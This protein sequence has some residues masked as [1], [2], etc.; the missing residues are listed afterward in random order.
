MLVL[1]TRLL[2][3][4]EILWEK[5]YGGKNSEYLFDAI[6]TPD[7][8]F[9]LAGSS[10][11]GKGGSKSDES[12]G[13]YDYWVWKMTEKGDLEWQKSFG[14]TADDHL[15]SIRLT[16]DGGFILAGISNS[17]KDGDKKEDSKGESDFW[18]IKLDAK[19]GEL[20][21]RTIGGNGL[22]NLYSIASTSDGGYIIG[23]TSSSEI[24]PVPEDGKEDEFRKTVANYG[25]LDYWVIKLNASGNITWQKTYGGSY[26]DELR[27]IE[28]TK[29]GGYIIGG[30]SNS[31]MSGNKTE[32]NFGE[33]D[34]WILKLDAS[35]NIT[36]QKTIGGDQDD[37]LFVLT[38]TF[39][40]GF[41]AGGSSN[42]GAM[43][44]K[45]KG[46][47]KGTDFWILKFD[48]NGAV[49]WQ[50]TYDYGKLDVLTSI[51]ENQDGTLLIGGYAQSEA[52]YSKGILGKLAKASDKEGINDYIALKISSKGEE[53]WTQTVGSRGDEVLRK[54]VETRDGGYV[55]AGTSNGGAS[56]DKNSVQGGNDFWVV[57]LKDKDKKEETRI[58]LE[59]IPNP[60]ITYSNVIVNY[61]YKKGTA[62]LYDL[63]GRILQTYSIHGERTIP[64][65]LSGLPRAIYVVEIKTDTES[66]GVKIIKK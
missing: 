51:V 3:S 28:P 60:A 37:N 21:Q 18:I 66:G 30:Y 4:Q 50:E 56:R 19:G 13:N 43:N 47:G 34:Y 62:T 41:I 46:N 31:P 11:S 20:W 61:E 25:N 55:L 64:V 35:G 5:S 52:S 23:G 36:W 44:C 54:L 49:T 10:I 9:I 33:G 63:N 8:G 17:P 65:D 58:N 29:D 1:T 2:F 22:E 24:T 53:L 15:Q 59:A 27:S 48:E 7:Y 26:A 12:K 14:G 45:T 39:D 40:G 6:P 32:D 16:N 42:S 57:K 38:Q